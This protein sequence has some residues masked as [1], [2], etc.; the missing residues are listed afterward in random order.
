ME[1][2]NET[3]GV[4]VSVRGTFVYSDGSVEREKE[5]SALRLNKR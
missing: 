5:A 3:S 1:T 4:Q 2:K